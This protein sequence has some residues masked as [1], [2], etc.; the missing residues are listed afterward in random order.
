AVKHRPAKDM[1]ALLSQQFKSES[2]VKIV[3]DPPSNCLL[4]QARPKV[5]AQLLQ[6]LE[7]LD[8]PPRSVVVDVW[9]VEVPAKKGEELRDLAGTLRAV[10][11]KIDAL[12]RKS[13]LG[14]VKHLQ[15]TATENHL[16]SHMSGEERGYIMSA[17]VT[18]TGLTTKSMS[19][20]QTGTNVKVTPR[21]TGEK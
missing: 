18:A 11:A 8:R 10:P 5:F 2:G 13:L 15:L 4:L 21:I 9:I 7:Q 1:A 3:A 14:A 16:V 20:R 12:Q 17:T 6:V 19:R